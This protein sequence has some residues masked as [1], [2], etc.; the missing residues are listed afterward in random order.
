MD[1]KVKNKQDQQKHQTIMWNC[2]VLQNI[3]LD[4][5]IKHGDVGLMEN[6]LLQ[7]LFWFMRG[8]NT[9]YATEVLEL[10]QGQHREWPAEVK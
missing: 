9:N 3:V 10:L 8:R 6:M 4:Q 1:K 5:A 7:L 2:D